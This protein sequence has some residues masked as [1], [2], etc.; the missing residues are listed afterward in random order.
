MSTSAFIKCMSAGMLV[1]GA[2]LMCCSGKK[3]CMK[4]SMIGRALK[5]MGDVVEDVSAIFGF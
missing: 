4:K 3:T 2:V 1:G 5:S